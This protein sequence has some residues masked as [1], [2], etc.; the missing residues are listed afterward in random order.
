MVTLV[1]QRLNELTPVFYPALEITAAL[2][3][4]DRLFTFLTLALETTAPWTPAATFTHMLTVFADWIV[5]LRIGT[6]AGTK[7]RPAR[8]ADL[9]AL[10]PGWPSSPGP[11]AHYAAAG[12]DLIAIYQ[13]D[14]ETLSVT[15]ARAPVTMVNPTDTPETPDEYHPMYLS[16]AIYRLRQVEGGEPFKAALPLLGE[17]LDAAGE[18]AG[19]MRAR[20][21]GSGYDTLPMEFAL[22]DRSLL[23]GLA[24][25]RQGNAQMSAANQGETK[26][27]K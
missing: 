11:A 1:G 5:P 14:G 24:S 10:D 16:Y 9:W 15:Y 25:E 22:W 7:V 18:Y 8:F 23:F 12:A 13:Q 27:D 20:N 26:G 19:Y 21:I 17:Y 6:S 2:N 3:E 4:A